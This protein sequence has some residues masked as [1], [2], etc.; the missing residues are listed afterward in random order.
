MAQQSLL[1]DIQ[2][3]YNQFTKTEKKIA[4]FV[5]KNTN[6]VLFMSITDLA[7]AC[8]VADA[9]VHRFCRTMGL[10]GYQEFKMKLSLS[11]SP[12][13]GSAKETKDS[14][15][16]LDSLG[17]TLDQI[18]QGHISA[19][20][21]TRLL[22]QEEEVE[23]TLRMMEEAKT[24]Y[25][26]GVGDSLLS[27]KE[28]RNKFLRITNKV[29]CVDDPH[30]QAMTAS[31]ADEKD[32]IVIISYSGST[33][34]NVH[35]AKIAKKSGAKVV[36]ITRFLKSPLT[37]YTD[38]LLVCGSNE[39]PLDGGSMGAKLSQLYIIDVLFQEYYRRNK[40]ASKENN[41]KTSKAVVEKLY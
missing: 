20:K 4:E 23:K 36:G 32:L 9:S 21:E 29:S 27:A 15:L 25:F 3:S 40:E 37:S 41:R 16:K 11:M 12:D 17:F 6:Q 18:L 24:I 26:F 14:L 7:D 1:L 2:V 10:K 35:V 8:K 39:G 19:L 22:I 33:K 28:A 31:M 5:I 13:E 30:M 34:D 38:T